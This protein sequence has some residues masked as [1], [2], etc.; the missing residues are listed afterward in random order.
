MGRQNKAAHVLLRLGLQAGAA[1][2]VGGRRLPFPL[3]LRC[4]ARRDFGA[5]SHCRKQ[6]IQGRYWSTCV[7]AATVDLCAEA[8]LLRASPVVSS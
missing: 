4:E 7:S 6:T 2:G 3:D 8:H 1:H 5:R